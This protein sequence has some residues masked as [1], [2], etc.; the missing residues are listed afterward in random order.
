MEVLANT[1]VV[2][3]L[4]YV[5]VSNQHIVQLKH[6]QCYMP[7]IFQFKKWGCWKAI[8]RFKK[9]IEL[10]DSESTTYQNM[11]DAVKAAMREQFIALNACIRYENVLQLVTKF[12][13]QET[14][15]RRAK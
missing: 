7:I 6:A 10:N 8:G 1:M 3:I 5:N 11:R 15:K 14:R 4:Q 9:F 2:I 13:P 12:L